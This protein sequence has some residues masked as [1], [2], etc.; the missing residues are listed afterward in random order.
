MA[1]SYSTILILRGSFGEEK[2]EQ[3][4][5][6]FTEDQ[7]GCKLCSTANIDYFLSPKENAKDLSCWSL[8]PFAWNFCIPL[9]CLVYRF[10]QSNMAK[11]L[12]FL[13]N[14]ISRCFPVFSAPKS[15][16]QLWMVDSPGMT[17]AIDATNWLVK[18]ET[19]VTQILVFQ[20]LTSVKP[21]QKRNL[22]SWNLYNRSCQ[23]TCTQTKSYGNL[24]HVDITPW[25]VT[26][27]FCGSCT[28]STGIVKCVKYHHANQYWSFFC[29]W[30]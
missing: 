4:F 11:A 13:L 22:D 26:F 15:S 6:S 20:Q 10:Q 29:W 1:P 25:K 21:N 12:L 19:R 18:S 17:W 23:K 5:L 3:D 2:I 27:W 30:K 16:C 9:Y 8:S 24:K 7:T 14:G 28:L